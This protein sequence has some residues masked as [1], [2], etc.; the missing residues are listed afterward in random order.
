[1]CPAMR[2]PC[3]PIL[4]RTDQHDDTGNPKRLRKAIDALEKPTHIN[5]LNVRALVNPQPLVSR[6]APH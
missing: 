5:K 6:I 4:A 2:R 1:M 3:T